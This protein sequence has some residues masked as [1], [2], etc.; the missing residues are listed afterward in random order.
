VQTQF[1]IGAK[2]DILAPHEHRQ[3]LKHAFDNYL[4]ERYRGI[5]HMRLPT[6]TA[7]A[8]SS[9]L[10]MPSNGVTCGPRDG[11]IWSLRRLVFSG[12]TAGA[13]PDIVNLYFNNAEGSPVWQLN[14]NSF[15]AT[16]GRLEL[17]MYGG[18][19]LMVTSLGT[20]ASTSVV[21]LTGELLECPAEM[22]GKLA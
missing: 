5:K 12:L 7:I 17:T 10:A 16:F 20:F 15:G 22:I 6:M 3:N 21:T 19:Q 9:T 18:D 4:I 14:G 11:F 1:D 2:A 13:S 8:A